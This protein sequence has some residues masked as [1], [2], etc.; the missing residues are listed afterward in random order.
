MLVKN[1]L[2][3]LGIALTGLLLLSSGVFAQGPATI[4]PG[5]T[6]Q[7]RPKPDLVAKLTVTGNP[8]VNAKGSVEVPIRVSIRN[9]G[10]TSAGIF[11]TAVEYKG[12]KGGDVVAFTVPGQS[13]I[14]YPMTNGPLAA[15]ATVTFSGKVTFIPS[16]RGVKVDLR[17]TADSCSGD[18]FKPDYCRVDESNEGNNSSAPV[19]VTLP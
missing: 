9:Q 14:W 3:L 10:R 2:S 11:K 1:F 18:E 19:T 7:I 15:G 13:S 12:P 16:V 17:A 4:K 8:T 6:K 5:S